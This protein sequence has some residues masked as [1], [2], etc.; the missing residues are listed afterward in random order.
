MNLRLLGFDQFF[1]GQLD[2]YESEINRVA[3]VMAVHRGV[4]EIHNGESLYKAPLKAVDEVMPTV[5]DFLLIEGKFTEDVIKVAKIFERKG[6]LRRKSAGTKLESQAI[7]ANLDTVLLVSSM[8]EEFNL[9]RLE[10]Y[11]VAIEDSGA[12][13][14]IVLSKADLTDESDLFESKISDSFNSIQIT[15]VSSET[16]EGIQDIEEILSSG[17]TAAVVGSSGVGKSTLINCL[18]KNAD[19]KT[20]AISFFDKGSHTTTSRQVILSDNG[21]LI[22]D[23]PGMREFSPI[24]ESGSLGST[25]EDIELAMTQCKYR[26]C[27]HTTE[28]GCQ[29]LLSIQDGS[30]D[31]RRWKN[32]GKLQR[33]QQRLNDKSK[34][35]SKARW[36]DIHK[37]M[38]VIQKDGKN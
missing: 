6:L 9:N 30:I 38:R 31:E 16:G 33:E 15:R 22:I 28:E 10:R 1:L 34:T 27:S 23:T 37:A 29:I 24:I 18:C 36:K 4:I 12:T 7:A 11:L 2:D 17:V 25:F 20:K 26:N 8:N 14:V 21:A 32:F 3:R 5:G 19:Q 13:P 35:N